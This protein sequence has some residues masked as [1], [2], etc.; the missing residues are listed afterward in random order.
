MS[1]AENRKAYFNYEILEKYEAGIVLSG[2]EVKSLRKGQV[3]LDGSF[4]SFRGGLPRIVGMHINPYQPGNPSADSDPRRERT[5]LLNKTELQELTERS[6]SDGL[7][8]IPL[9]V[10]LKG[11]RI[12][13]SIGLARGKKKHD[14]RETIKKRD[15]EREIRRAMR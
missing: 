6:E 13:L 3:S 7:A 11:R 10:Y 4:I 5:L 1:I 8:V 2:A 12:K 9:A 14:K 15:A